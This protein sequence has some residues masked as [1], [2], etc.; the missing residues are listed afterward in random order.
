MDLKVAYI[1][2]GSLNWA[3]VFMNDMARKEPLSGHVNFHDIDFEVAELNERI[4][5]RYAALT[6]G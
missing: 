2:G 5:A 6:G 4:G 3:R 1:G